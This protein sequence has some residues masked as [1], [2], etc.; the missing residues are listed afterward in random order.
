MNQIKI[1]N[2]IIGTGKP[3][4]YIAEAGVNHNGSLKIAKKLV[5]IAVDCGADAVKFQSFL[6]DEIINSLKLLKNEI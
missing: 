6:A 3:V 5:D 1:G 4:F 2:K